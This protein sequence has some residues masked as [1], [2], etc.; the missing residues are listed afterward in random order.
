[1]FLNICDKHIPRNVTQ[2]HMSF[3][4]ERFSCAVCAVISCYFYQYLTIFGE[5]SKAGVPAS[6]SMLVT[7]KINIQIKP[8]ID[9]AGTTLVHKF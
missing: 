5:F 7:Q 1:M 2:N 4:L 3:Y 6:L 8:K 9:A